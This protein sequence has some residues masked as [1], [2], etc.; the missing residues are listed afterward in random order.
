MPLLPTEEAPLLVYLILA[1][2]QLRIHGDYLRT[3]TP[4]KTLV[5]WYARVT[6]SA[7]TPSY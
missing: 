1:R 6:I 2:I 5:Y 7:L 4:E 3:S